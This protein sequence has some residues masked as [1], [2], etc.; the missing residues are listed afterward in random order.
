MKKFLQKC[1]VRSTLVYKQISDQQETENFSSLAF[2]KSLFSNTIVFIFLGALVLLPQLGFA[3]AT[4]TDPALTNLNYKSTKQGQLKK[5]AKKNF[6]SA[7]ASGTSN[8][9]VAN[10]AG[11]VSGSQVNSFR[12]GGSCFIPKDASYT[13]LPRNDDGSYGPIA[14]GCNFNLYATSYHQVWINT[15]GNLTFNGPLAMY[16][17]LGFPYNVPMVAGFWADVNTEI[18]GQIFFKQ[19]SSSI[20]VTWDAVEPYGSEGEFSNTFQ[21]VLTDGIDPLLGNGRNV[22]LN[23]QNIGWSFGAASIFEPATVGINHGN[24]INYVQ[25]GLFLFDNNNYDGPGGNYDG[26]YHLNGLC[27]TFNVTNA[28]NIE[29][30]SSNFPQNN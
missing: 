8:S 14:S 20:I 3:Q 15:N 26:M 4:V 7:T 17:P 22:G 18:G 23:H 19:T 13:D 2:G 6:V 12:T 28:G 21:I 1:S 16:N 30:S 29:P 9:R 11:T 5:A 10:T 24:G 27:S 25:V